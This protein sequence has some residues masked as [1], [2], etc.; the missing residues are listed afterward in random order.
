MAK[1]RSHPSVDWAGYFASIRSQCPW[2]WHSWRQGLILIDT[3]HGIAQPIDHYDARLYVLVM[4]NAAV[5]ALASAHD[6]SDPLC[7][8]LFSYPGYGEWATPV[9]VLIQQ[10]RQRLNQL[11]LQ[12]ESKQCE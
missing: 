11:R 2:S 6:H 7:E 1:A 4:P 5:E 9:S 10:P 12:I 8:W 3:Y